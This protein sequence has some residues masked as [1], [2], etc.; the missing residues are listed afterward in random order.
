MRRHL[1]NFIIGVAGLSVIILVW[2]LLTTYGVVSRIFVPTPLATIEALRRG[3]ASGVLISQTQATV[4]LMIQG[5]L[6]ASAVAI[7]L[8]V[9]IGV[10]PAARRALEPLLEFIRPLPAS[11]IIPVAVAL[12]G[13]TPHMILGV[14]T[15][16]SLWPTLLA[17]V[18]GV[19]T[20]EP[21]LEEVARALGMSRLSFIWKIGL[22]NAVPDILSGMRLSLTFSFILAIVTEMLAGENGLGTAIL[23]A[24]RLFRSPDIFAGLLVLAL[25]GLVS[26]SM[27]QAVERRLLRWRANG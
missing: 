15:F 19:S 7:F 9:L 27:L 11:A 4:L 8:G 23:L 22:P 26:N 16:G 3:F 14:V 10:W 1:D 13:L 24:G 17:T 6:L 12:F 21:R 18:H 5:W 20:V 25:I 2:H